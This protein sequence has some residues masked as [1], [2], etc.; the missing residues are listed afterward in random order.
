M[1]ALGEAQPLQQLTKV[2]CGAA[3]L[4]AIAEDYGLTGLD[5]PTLARLIGITKD[6]AFP[7]QLVAAARQLGLPAEERRF[8]TLA[9]AKAVT[10]Q[11][12]PIIANILS[13]TVPGGG[14]FVV[15]TKIDEA[16]VHLMDPNVKGNRRLLSHDEMLRR[17]QTRQGS[18]VVIARPGAALGAA[19][20]VPRWPLAVT[21]L[22]VLTA[23]VLIVVEARRVNARRGRRR[24]TSRAS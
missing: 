12:L 21:G 2:T 8:R 18:G 17:W 14:H 4:L 11:G 6:G 13:F 19:T 20:P 9:E 15:V 22:L 23:G 24:S 7:V 16:G 5:E 3:C 10:D 1:T